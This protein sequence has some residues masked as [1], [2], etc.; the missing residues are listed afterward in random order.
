MTSPGQV[1]ACGR[2]DKLALLSLP[3]LTLATG[4]PPY[5]QEI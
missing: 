5:T 4:V 2:G 3:L 1:T